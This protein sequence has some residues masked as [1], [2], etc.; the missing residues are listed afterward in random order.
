MP[1]VM[2]TWGKTRADK[3]LFACLFYLYEVNSLKAW[4]IAWKYCPSIVDYPHQYIVQQNIISQVITANWKNIIVL[5]HHQGLP[6]LYTM[7]TW[8]QTRTDKSCQISSTARL[9]NSYCNIALIMIIIIVITAIAIVV[10]II[11]IAIIEAPQVMAR[12]G[13]TRADGSCKLSASARLSYSN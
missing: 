12:R 11:L 3:S 8:G 9:G 4:P 2:P 6:M 5:T 7:A 13:Q 10:A 1:C